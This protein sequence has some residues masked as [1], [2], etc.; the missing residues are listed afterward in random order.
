MTAAFGRLPQNGAAPAGDRIGATILAID[1]D[2][3]IRAVI[4]RQLDRL[5]Y[6]PLMASD[7]RGGL[8][9]FDAHATDIELV[10]LDWSMPGK[11]GKEVLAELL[12]RRSDLRVVLVTGSSDAMI[13]EHATHDAVSILR[14][15][16]TPAQLTLI[17]RTVLGA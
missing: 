2:A 4:E 17:V 6:R 14:K 15:P 11:S 9:L 5:G 8:R 16:F 7:G 3:A 12:S 10:L 1:D 13:D